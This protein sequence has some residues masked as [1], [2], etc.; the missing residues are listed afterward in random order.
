MLSTFCVDRP[1]TTQSIMELISVRAL[2]DPRTIKLK[3]N[4][5]RG[6]NSAS[7]LYRLRD[8][9]WS[10]NFIVNLCRQSGVAWSARRLPTVVNLDF[11]D[12]GHYLF[13]QVSPHVSS[14]G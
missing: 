1:L 2:V 6:F 4:K 7:D 3:T 9:R 13:F 8:S 5:F 11:L 14:R 10:A 12:R